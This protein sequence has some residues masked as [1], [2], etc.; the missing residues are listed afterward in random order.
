M[1]ALRKRPIGIIL[2]VV[3][4]FAAGAYWLLQRRGPAVQKT[5]Y[6][7]TFETAG[8]WTV[9]SDPNAMGQVKDG[10]YEMFVELSG[11]IFW[12]TGGR[13][14][15]DAVYE[16]DATPV[17]GTVDNGYGLLF[18]VNTEEQ[19]FYVFKVSSDGY[20]FIG[21]CADNCAETVALVDRDWFDSPAVA[22]GLNVTNHLRVVAS[23]ARMSFYVNDTL[24]GEAEEEN[25]KQG[26]IGLLS[27]TFTPGGLRVVFDNFT[28]MPIEE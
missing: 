5:P 26:D 11:D 18:R 21:R 7:E 23:G 10:A 4:M 24:V 27:E 6:I 2:I 3:V 19:R 14:F 13:L 15:R 1:S 9:G 17:E 20:V 22:Q 25:L 16:V 8:S 12:V 28:V